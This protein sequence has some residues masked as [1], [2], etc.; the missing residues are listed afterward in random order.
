MEHT[1]RKRQQ[2]Y[3]ED[4]RHK[5]H[6]G[7]KLI[8]VIDLIG[9][10]ENTLPRFLNNHSLPPIHNSLMQASYPQQ[11]HP[12]DIH[13]SLP[14]GYN[15]TVH[16][17]HAPYLQQYHTSNIPRRL[18]SALSSMIPVS[19]P[20]QY[21]I[22]DTYSNLSSIHNPT[23]QAPHSQ[24]Y[25]T[26][27]T[28]I[29]YDAGY[30]TNPG[31]KYD[32]TP[33]THHIVSDP[34]K[35]SDPAPLPTVGND[36]PSDIVPITEPVLCKEQADLVDLILSGRNVF[37]TGSAGCGKSTVLKAF[38]KRFAERNVHVNI[39]APTGRAALDING[40]TTWS[41]AGWTPDHHKK[42]LRELK[43]AAHG[44]FVQ[45]R[46]SETNVLVIDE[47]SMVENLHFE[48]LNAVMKEARRSDK[49]FGGVQLV[50]TGDVS[51][52]ELSSIYR[53]TNPS[54]YQFM[55]PPARIGTPS[56]SDIL[57]SMANRFSSANYRP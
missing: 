46:L 21:H 47:I 33:P 45:K 11:Y 10:D 52:D 4:P 26:F 7:S 49:A 18:G 53:S 40:T 31:L 28:P 22:P 23:I 8:E 35:P 27:D 42:P 38:V 32:H 56:A 12:S 37:Y 2:S 3:V 9:E 15:P 30:M 20:Q 13:H 43:S 55:N 1:S 6:A 57:Q 16:E 54:I 5:R 51:D 14:P 50:V 39:I 41:Y 48:R 17:M 36:T 29:P 34:F 44:K 25:H 19:Y 24:P